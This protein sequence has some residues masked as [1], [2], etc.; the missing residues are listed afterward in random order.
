LKECLAVSRRGTTEAFFMRGEGERMGNVLGGAMVA[1][2]GA[3]GAERR[4]HVR[5]SER[6][7]FECDCGERL[8]LLGSVVV[9]NGG[10]VVLECDCGERFTLAGRLAP[11]EPEVV[12]HEY[13]EVPSHEVERRYSSLDDC[14]EWLEGKEAREEYYAR[15]EQA[16]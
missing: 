13:W 14:F 4:A 12:A 11:S 1:Y 3:R 15:L 16:G 8:V 6:T 7:V 9:R 5:R 10:R 2:G